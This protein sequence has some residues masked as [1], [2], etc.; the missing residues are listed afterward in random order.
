MSHSVFGRLEVNVSKG[1]PIQRVFIQPYFSLYKHSFFLMVSSGALYF[2][3]GKSR[4]LG[5]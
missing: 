5:L 1:K 4:N 3:A 2:S